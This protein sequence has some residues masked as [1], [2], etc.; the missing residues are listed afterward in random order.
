[1]AKRK[2]ITIQDK[3]GEWNDMLEDVIARNIRLLAPD[4][5]TPV[6]LVK[7]FMKNG[8]TCIRAIRDPNFKN[9]NI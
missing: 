7:L 8:T 3:T 1:M 6:E 9:K 2:T 5:R 4:E